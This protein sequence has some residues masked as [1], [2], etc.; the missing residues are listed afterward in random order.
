ME[1]KIEKSNSHKE[2][3]SEG[4]Q[5]FLIFMKIF[6]KIFCQELFMILQYHL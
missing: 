6:L 4:I 3:K 5:I 1:N 2:S